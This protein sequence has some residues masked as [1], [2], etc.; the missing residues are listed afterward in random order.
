PSWLVT[1]TLPPERVERTAR[2][3]SAPTGA[4]PFV[5]EARRWS[6][7]V[8]DT[9][10][11]PPDTG[12][13]AA[14]EP[15]AL[16]VSAELA[17]S[18]ILLVDDNVDL[19]TYVAGLLKRGFP[20]VET[21]TNGQDAL[22]QA[23]VRPPDLILSDV[24][25]PVLDGFGLVRALRADERTRAIPIILLSARAG[26]EATVE[27][28]QSGADDYL[29][30]PFSARELLVRVRTQL[31]MARVRRQV[32]RNA[33]EKDS[34]RESVRTRDEFLRL[35]SHELR[36]PVSALSL[37]V[38]SL[39]RSLEAQAPAPDTAPDAA[40]VKA[41]TTE[42]H[43]QRLTRLV[44]QLLD[45]SELVTGPL[46]LSREE[47]DLTQLAATVVAQAREKA[48]RADCVLTL[49]APLPV[50]GRYDR[51]RLH[52]LLDGLVDNAL[53]FGAGRPVTVSVVREAGRVT[54]AVRD[55]GAGI[56]PEDQE[57]IFGRFERAVPAK[58][59]GGFGLGLWIARHIAEA[60]GGSIHLGPTEGG[61]ATFSAV[62][63]LD[64]T[65]GG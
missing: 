21:A 4:A 12:A 20:H 7:D 23:R 44:E 35:V 40:R 61:G 49:E 10:I 60:H 62:L 58:H 3:R 34:L 50:V 30:K 32:V 38:Q 25:M 37:N 63:P 26:D 9:D 19:R 42:K 27:G 48:L 47:V 11:S 64:V 14:S 52:Q 57:R 5:E 54:L 55:H 6:A 51:A 33:V 8:I 56:E 59:H 15:P 65:P 2:P 31:D 46:D 17:R 22:E 53:K 1:P 39:V 41:R 18:R 28:L 13:P 36:T 24:M 43:L 16:E 45:V 29:V